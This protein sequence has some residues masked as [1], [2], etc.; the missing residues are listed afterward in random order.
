MESQHRCDLHLRFGPT[1]PETCRPKPPQTFALRQILRLH[2]GLFSLLPLL[3][4]R[5]I[6][7]LS[8]VEVKVRHCE[9]F[10]SREVRF[11]QPARRRRRFPGSSGTYLTSEGSR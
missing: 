11:P 4:S 9:N 7:L 10:E 6:G 2:S 1:G 5:L 8:A 3:S